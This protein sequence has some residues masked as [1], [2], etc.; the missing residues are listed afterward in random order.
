MSTTLTLLPWPARPWGAEA[1][2][3]AHP[4]LDPGELRRWHLRRPARL[5]VVSGLA[6][7]TRSGGTEDHFLR[8]GESLELGRGADVLIQADGADPLR[9]RWAPPT[10]AGA[11]SN[12][13]AR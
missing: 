1:A 12:G 2:A 13:A 3:A 8:S 6:W 4:W 5:Q 7:V 9:W 10:P 11:L